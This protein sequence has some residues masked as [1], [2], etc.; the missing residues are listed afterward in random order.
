MLAAGK[1]SLINRKSFPGI[2]LRYRRPDPVHLSKDQRWIISLTALQPKG[3]PLGFTSLG[4]TPVQLTAAPRRS[5]AT[6]KAIHAANIAN[7]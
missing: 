1:Y 3:L 7:F 4:D 5:S 2:E 6:V